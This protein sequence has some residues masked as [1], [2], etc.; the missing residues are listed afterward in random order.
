[1]RVPDS[2]KDKADASFIVRFSAKGFPTLEGSRTLVD[3]AKAKPGP[4]AARILAKKAQA[5]GDLDK[6]VSIYKDALVD[7]PDNVGLLL[8]FANLLTELPEG[9]RHT[10]I[11]VTVTRHLM[12]VGSQWAEYIRPLLIEALLQ[13]GK[14]DQARSEIDLGLKA[15]P[16]DQKFKDFAARLQAAGQKAKP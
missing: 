5:A 16:G 14:L 2:F 9:K 8:N 6:A 4:H 11:A 12:K 7:Q 10:D 13:D 3:L 15:A 1:V